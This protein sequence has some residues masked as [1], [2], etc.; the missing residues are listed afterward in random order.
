M[1]NST[2]NLPW[3][4]DALN[5]M[6]ICSYYIS[7]LNLSLNTKQVSND[8]I[9]KHLKEQDEI[10]EKDFKKDLEIIIEQNKTI[11]RLLKGE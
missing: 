2:T 1:D 8:D 7:V 10:L 9:S 6:A 4:N 5:L 3:N 11:I